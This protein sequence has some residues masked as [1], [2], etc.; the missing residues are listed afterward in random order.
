MIW[1]FPIFLETPMYWFIIT[2]KTILAIELGSG[3]ASHR[4]RA[5][6]YRCTHGF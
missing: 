5:F 6:H 3:V 2:P 4:H 1:G